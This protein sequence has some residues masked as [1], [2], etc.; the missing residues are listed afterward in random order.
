MT[1]GV[2]R[3]PAW[4]TGRHLA[5]TVVALCYFSV[6]F[7]PS[8]TIAQ[9]SLEDRCLG[10]INKS[11]SEARSIATKKDF[12]T[13]QK[14]F[15]R[16]FSSARSSGRTASFGMSYDVLSLSSGS[17]RMSAEAVAEQYCEQNGAVR[18]NDVDYDNYTSQVPRDAFS[19]YEACLK[20]ARDGGVIFDHHG[21]VFTH[22]E[23]LFGVRF[24]ATTEGETARI[25]WT[26]VPKTGTTCSWEGSAE[27]GN[28]IVMQDSS[29]ANLRCQRDNWQSKSAVVVDRQNGTAR[30]RFDWQ[31]YAQ[32]NGEYH[33]VSKLYEM[34][35]NILEL[36]R[37]S[38]E[39]KKTL[40]PAG[41]IA[42]FVQDGRDVC[43]EHWSKADGQN[44]HPNLSGRFMVG[45]GTYIQDS[46]RLFSVGQTG[47]SHKTRVKLMTGGMKYAPHPDGQVI[48]LHGAIVEWL[49]GDSPDGEEGESGFHR[50]HGDEWDNWS[51]HPGNW[52]NHF[53]PYFAVLFCVKN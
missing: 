52:I 8:L 11:R 47:G 18:R 48:G 7:A 9:E 17:S 14:N 45:S 27:T 3:T 5:L 29:Q 32:A 24:N 50:I 40:V 51:Y 26:A 49:R 39:L 4:A 42:A 16:E 2:L 25:R 10:V 6:A 21:S 1:N 22:N 43:P 34:Q 38:A 33:P 37:I 36:Q 28:V 20:S 31:G 19:A 46:N 44:G 15:C 13:H 23:L 53:P 41:T 12:F 30:M 35:Q